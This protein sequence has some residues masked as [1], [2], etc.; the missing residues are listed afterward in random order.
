MKSAK[1]LWQQF[2]IPW[3]KRPK[4]CERPLETT[5]TRKPKLGLALS[6]GGAKGLAHVGVVQVLE[7]NGIEVHAISG[8]SMGAYVGSLWAAGFSG[9]DL[10]ILA[11]EMH[12]RRQFWKLAD[13][14]LP[15]LSGLFKG[16]KAKKH[17]KKSLGDLRFEDLARKLL[18]ITFDLDTRERLVKRAGCIADAVHASCAMPGIISPVILDGHRCSD[19][20]VVD[21]VPVSALKKFTDVDYV[22]AVSVVPTYDDIENKDP[23]APSS[24]PP[25]LKRIVRKI[26]RS[27]NLLAYGNVVDTLRRSLGA[28]QIRIAHESIKKADICLH[29][30]CKTGLWHDYTNFEKY[31]EAGRE[32]TLAQLT[33]IKALFEPIPDPSGLSHDP[34]SNK[35]VVGECVSP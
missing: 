31:I 27:T 16:E 11:A 22:I 4:R 20:G 3:R 29:P 21:P 1:K 15:P 9:K 32:A 10:E 14:I 28:S 24:S 2:S 18:V 25:L 7:E 12:D 33:E 17:L 19:G 30:D 8:S 23:A 35:Q 13:P 26:H 6:A 5:P 34:P